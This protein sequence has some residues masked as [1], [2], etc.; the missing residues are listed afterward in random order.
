MNK[1][2]FPLF[3]FT[4]LFL[5]V[6][7]INS[8][9]FLYWNEI[10]QV[11]VQT[12]GERIITPEKFK[13]FTL[14]IPAIRNVLN[15][16]PQEKNIQAKNSNIIL[17]LP[18]PDGGYGR[19]QIVES[20]I[21]EKGLAD[22]FPEIKTYLGMGIDDPYATVR[23]D[24][25]P[26]GFHA[27][28]MT[29]SDMIFIDPYAKGDTYNYISYYKKD[30]KPL[31][32]KFSCKVIDDKKTNYQP[33]LNNFS[34]AEGQLR[35]YRV[36]IGATGEYTAYFGGTVTQGLAAIVV[37]LNRVDGVYEREVSVRMILVSNN[38][39][40][41]YTNASTDPYTN[42]D[43]EVMLGQNQT[44]CDNLIGSA[45][46]DIGHVFSTG[47]GGV[48]YLGCVC[49]AGM[50]AQGVTGSSAPVGDPYDI[51]YVAHEMGHQ[52]GGNHT[53]N[54]TTGS[55]GGG[56]REASAA[57]EPGS[58]STIM[59]YAGI[60]SPNDLQNNSD[61]YF[62]LKSLLEIASFTTYGGGNS[63]AQI[64][65]TG[66]HN[67]VVTFESVGS[68]IPKS[69]PFSLTGSAT[70]ADNDSLVYCWEEYDLGPAGNWSNPSGNAPIFRSFAPSA[71]GTRIFPKLTYLL[72]NTQHIGEI[73]P[74]YAR[75]LNFYL[76]A[77]DNK[78]GGGG[79]GYSPILSLSVTNAA[80]PFLVTSPN[81]AV[82]WN[83]N[84]P[85]TVTWD[86]ANTNIS[87][88][89]CSN[90]N[91][92]LSTDG[93]NTFSITLISNTPNDGSEVVNL[94]MISTTTARI[95]V[96][97][98]GNVFFDISNA[99]FTISTVSG[100]GNLESHPIDFKLLQ[101]YPNPFNPSTMI[102]FSIPKKADVYL[103]VYDVTGKIVA[104]LINN[105]IMTEGNYSYEFDGS[106]LASGMYFYK[107]KAGSFEQTRR[108]VLL[109]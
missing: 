30:Y 46:Y 95:K 96:E 10:S 91:I 54:C 35:T 39:L 87:P 69:T 86:I 40:I 7:S 101:N 103:D 58:G 109:K 57:Y 20:P 85:Q 9:N 18:L 47:G 13:V 3:S 12:S 31:D 73:L 38:N 33:Q 88:V 62:V 26:L 32:K 72:S 80:G 74:S 104:K 89:N 82:T 27:M 16:A 28:I 93:G 75:D 34:F 6:G 68:T 70:D 81:T 60:C 97:A 48:A 15:T 11:N 63:C 108:M 25:T 17:F 21:M 106:T 99:N 65:T 78:P 42:N 8:Q 37:S 61:A 55:C 50:K 53:F 44:V 24:L 94:P 29:A 43:G 45:N 102:S 36:A 19:F 76:I 98:V 64:T 23:L 77:R 92:K 22:K 5:F 71:S 4:L 79:T 2:Y 83:A 67:P 41:V 107:L 49:T 105:E 59:A 52:F 66:N 100:I 56:N 1:Y 84:L 90:I 14:D 51:D